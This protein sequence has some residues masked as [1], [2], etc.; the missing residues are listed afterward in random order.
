[1]ED[2]G[3]DSHDQTKISTRHVINTRLQHCHHTIPF[4]SYYIIIAD[5]VKEL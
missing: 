5:I 2:L 1:M 3:Q 4:H